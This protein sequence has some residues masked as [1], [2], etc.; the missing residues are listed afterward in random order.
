MVIL[1]KNL[2]FCSSIYGTKLTGRKDVKFLEVHYGSDKD[3]IEK[4]Q[5]IYPNHRKGIFLDA[6]KPVP[7]DFRLDVE[8]MIKSDPLLIQ[9]IRDLKLE[10]LCQ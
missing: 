3:F 4:Y 6:R 9:T 5:K 2:V 7:R 8:H 10:E 1:Y